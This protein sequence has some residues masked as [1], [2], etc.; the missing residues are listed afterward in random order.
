MNQ[1]LAAKQRAQQNKKGGGKETRIGRI[2]SSFQCECSK[3]KLLPVKKMI[4]K[5]NISEI[6]P[7]SRR[8]RQSFLTRSRRSNFECPE[9]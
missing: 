1:V 6:K 3:V 4:S 8:Y 7:S 5:L 9:S 2:Y